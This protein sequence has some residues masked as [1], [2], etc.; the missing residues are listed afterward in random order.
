MSDARAFR[1][2]SEAP[3]RAD[4]MGKSTLFASERLLVGLNA[5]EPGQEHALHAHDGMEKVYVGVS[6]RGH[7]LLEDGELEIAPG[8]VVVTPAGVAH[9]VRADAG[10]RLLLLAMLAPAP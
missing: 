8:I 1:P 4:K 3:Y 10:E 6:G 7:V 9:G 2:E 5:F